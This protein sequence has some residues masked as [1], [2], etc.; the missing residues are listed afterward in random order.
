MIFFIFITY[1]C[2][3][4]TVNHINF[5]NNCQNGSKTFGR[6]CTLIFK[7]S[8]LL[9][10]EHVVCYF[11]METGEALSRLSLTPTCKQLAEKRS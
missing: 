3:N 9:K 6:Q 4:L 8:K 2:F 5:S 11:I 1:L 7:V 10:V